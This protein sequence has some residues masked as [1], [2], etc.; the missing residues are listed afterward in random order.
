MITIAQTHIR[1]NQI[2]KSSGK[3]HAHYLTQACAWELEDR[4]AYR[5]LRPETRK[6]QLKRIR[7]QIPPKG[8]LLLST[9]NEHRFHSFGLTPVSWRDESLGSGSLALCHVILRFVA[10]FGSALGGA[11]LPS[12]P[13]H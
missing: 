1:F 8:S 13:A 12:R 4:V 7:H 5:E 11:I 2:S 6:S 10:F 3:M 9:K